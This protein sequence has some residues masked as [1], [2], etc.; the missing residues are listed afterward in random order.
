M[1]WGEWYA[2]KS[3]HF[4]QYYSAALP[5]RVERWKRYIDSGE[6]MMHL[7][8]EEWKL[9]EWKDVFQEGS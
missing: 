1:G 2:H 8:Y 4:N 7:N 6:V 9:E 3:L 5:E